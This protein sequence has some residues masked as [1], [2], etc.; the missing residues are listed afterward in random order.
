MLI[1]NTEKQTSFCD[2]S[3]SQIPAL[4]RAHANSSANVCW[5]KKW[6][7]KGTIFENRQECVKVTV[8]EA[9]QEG[10]SSDDTQDLGQRE[11]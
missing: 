3:E 6:E 4:W 2:L 5:E 8:Q 1:W 9:L 10:D 7:N 11:S